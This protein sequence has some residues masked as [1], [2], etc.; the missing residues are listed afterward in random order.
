[1]GKRARSAAVA[2]V[3][4]GSH[5]VGKPSAARQSELYTRNL[6]AALCLVLVFA[7]VI[8][9][10]RTS[11]YGFVSYD[12]ENYVSANPDL[13][14]GLTPAGV[15]WAFTTFR[16]SNWHPLTWLSLLADRQLFG[17][18]PG[19]EHIV[20][21]CFHLASVVLLFVAFALMTGSFWRSFLV[22][23]IFGLH[24]CHVESVAWIAERKDV[25]STF[26]GLVTILFYVRY[27]K[28]PSVRRYV[29][30]ALSFALALMAKPMLVTLPFALLLLDL[31]PLS[32]TAWPPA[33]KTLKGLLV[34]KAP[35]FAMTAAASVA[36]LVAHHAMGAIVPLGKLPF[37]NRLAGAA[38]GYLTYISK[39]VWPTDLAV[40]YKTAPIPPAHALL[41]CAILLAV[42]IASFVAA[43]KRP[44]LLVGWLWY[45]GT[46]VPV[47]G[48]VQVG[49]QST[50][51]RYTYLP[52]IG[53]SLAAVWLV[54]DL[55]SRRQ[56]TARA[57]AVAACAGLAA[58]GAVS[59]H[60]VGYWESTKTLLA[61]SLAISDNDAIFNEHV[62]VCLG[63]EGNFAEA[64]AHFRRA[65]ELDPTR[66]DAFVNLGAA[67]A[68]QG[69]FDDAVAAYSKALSIDPRNAQ[70]HNALGSV[71]AQQGKL[72]DAVVSLRKALDIDPTRAQ[73]HTDLAAVLAEQGKR[74]E[75][76]KEFSKAV[77][78][79]PND[80]AAKAGLDRLLQGK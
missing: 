29:P 61:H 31:W 79:D 64:A 72:D 78:L 4:A 34:E 75:A 22:A 63:Q 19:A 53:L 45:V 65:A 3:K 43:K 38:T 12:D 62:G 74:A 69:L 68:C 76:A 39:A 70:A 14:K 16:G 71:L 47:I 26:L 6:A 58:L 41:P 33:W 28:A 11:S 17:I 56:A 51:D 13:D 60:Q 7:T 80:E 10:A 40:L 36:A 44:Y 46:L 35:L 1:V 73:A 54:A 57:A 32:R 55:V 5:A 37:P 77:S 49:V 67:L 52:H 18:N 9:Y 21:V 24:P 59:Y 30:V 48:V 2:A 15:A 23:G 25:L 20:N 8:V 27:A 42:T 50:A 66:A